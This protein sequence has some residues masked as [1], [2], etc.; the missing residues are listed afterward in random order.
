MTADS[1]RRQMALIIVVVAAALPVLWW[2][3][4]DDG[5]ACG[6]VR[7]ADVSSVVGSSVSA[8][9]KLTDDSRSG[10]SGCGFRTESGAIVS[11]WIGADGQLD[12]V[13]DGMRANGELAAGQP[14][15]YV[16]ARVDGESAVTMVDGRVVLVNVP[17]HLGAAARLAQLI[18][19]SG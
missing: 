6:V 2:L 10:A 5:E 18:A 4:P 9:E 19:T 8:G 1:P 13:F 11:V 7:R 16:Y 3:F 17:G 15:A 12:H 14:E